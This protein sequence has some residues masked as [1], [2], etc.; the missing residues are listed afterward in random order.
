MKR[1]AICMFALAFGALIGGNAMATVPDLIPV[2]G[3]LADAS[4]E[5]V[6]DLTDLT[7]SLYVDDSTTTALWTDTF[8]DVDVVDGFFTVY[9][10]SETALDF[11]SLISNS[12]IWMGVEVE[13]DGEMD[14][15]QLAAVPFAVEAGT[16][17]AVGSLTESDINSNFS[18][19]SHDHDGD[20]AALS[21]TH[22]WGDIT[23]IPAGF[24][25]GVDNFEADTNTN[26]ATMCSSGYFLNGDGS[27]D[28]V[29]TDTNT[30]YSAGTGLDLAGTTF[31]VDPT[32]FMEPVQYYFYNS[33]RVMDDTTGSG[34]TTTVVSDSLTA[35]VAGTTHVLCS[36]AARAMDLSATNT[37]VTLYSFIT[38]SS[39]GTYSS[40]EYQ[41]QRIT[42]PGTQTLHYQT[43]VAQR[44]YSQA[45]GT[46]TY[47]CRTHVTGGDEVDAAYPRMSLIF[48]PN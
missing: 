33:Y 27:C 39:T 22:A 13:T 35:P 37:Q 17:G 3:V 47:Y 29:P 30:T 28:A 15:F 36:Y 16:C 23:G 11:A 21:H 6:D 40:N 20:Y 38:T 42:Y 48:V 44:V 19:S 10:G 5:P 9:L 41:Y 43:V 14:R 18:A 4:D 1:V 31:S 2:Q 24:A 12:E 32:D 46:T 7:F 45:A 25:D 8:T 34:I 26:A